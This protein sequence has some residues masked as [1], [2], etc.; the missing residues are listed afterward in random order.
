[1]MTDPPRVMWLLNHSSAR[2][3]EVAMLKRLGV[4]EIFLPKSFPADP[5]FRS[6]SVDWSE[7]QNL[8]IPE[9]DLQF[10]NSVNWYENT[11]RDAWEI[12][13]RYFD[14]AFVVLYETYAFRTALRHFCGALVWRAYGLPRGAGYHDILNFYDARSGGVTSIQRHASAFFFGEAYSHLAEIEPDCLKRNRCYLPLG[15]VDTTIDSQWKGDEERIFFVCPDIGFNPYYGNIYQSFRK[16]FG[17]LPYAL[18]GAQPVVVDDP[19]ALGFVSR[20]Q[21]RLNMQRYR[22][23]YYHSQEPNHIHFHPFEAIMAGMPLVFMA[24]GMLDRMGGIGLPGRCETIPAARR[25]IRRI[26]KGDR[27]LIEKIRASQPVLLDSMDFDRAVPHWFEGLTRIARAAKMSKAAVTDHQFGSRR[28]RIAVILPQPYRGG[29]LRGALAVAQ[30]LHIGS[31]DAEEPA[32]IVFMHLD[33]DE[34][35]AE[36][37]FID[38][39]A[40][41]ARRAFTWKVIGPAEARRAM[42]YAGFETWEPTAEAYMVPDDGISQSIDCDLWLIISDRMST[43]LLPIKPAAL[44]VYDYLQRYEAVMPFGADA[45]FLAAAR[46]AELVLVTTDFTYRDAVQYAGVNPARVA[47]LPMLAPAFD[48][49]TDEIERSRPKYFLWTTN[50]APHKNHANAAEALRIYYEELDGRLACWV[51]GVHSANLLESDL[52][53]LQ[54]MKDTFS[55][56]KTLKK[57]VKW[58]GE[59]PDALYRRALAGACFLWHAGR[60]DNGTF[61]VI[62]A[63]R[64]GVPS[65]SSDYPAMR[66]IDRQFALNLAW[67][68]PYKPREMAEQLKW[69]EAEAATLR[70][71]LPD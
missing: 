30:A 13:N 24:G 44:V 53:E 42:R 48:Q 67:M 16:N 22:L 15:V 62:E 40:G 58:K 37:D 57:R 36:R 26:L 41:V 35:D 9:D 51:T 63:A 1:M 71:A 3:F 8:S 20:E 46:S 17:D 28:K 45:P 32:D 47:K 31:R 65:L 11:P 2:R 18:A 52:P 21:H 43:P 10:L 33:S 50:A 54:P 66:E 14:A 4:R 34:Y 61:S 27:S 49:R 56:S 39:A 12:A 23:M 19:N 29:T 60:I 70:G 55:G 7:D 5:N 69:M 68:S 25:K 38:L 59:L 64:L 6:A